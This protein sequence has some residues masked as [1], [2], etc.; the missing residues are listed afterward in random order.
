MDSPATPSPLN[1]PQG[2]SAAELHTL[3]DEAPPKRPRPR[4]NVPI[5]D[6]DSDDLDDGYFARGAFFVP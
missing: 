2:P 1:R 4:R 3:P 5:L 6:S